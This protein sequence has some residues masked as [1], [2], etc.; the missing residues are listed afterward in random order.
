ML[1][2]IEKVDVRLSQSPLS[3]SVMYFSASSCVRKH[4]HI[5]TVQKQRMSEEN[6][7]TATQRVVVIFQAF[8]KNI[9]V[10]QICQLFQVYNIAHCFN[11]QQISDWTS[12]TPQV[13]RSICMKN[14][15]VQW[16]C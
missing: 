5:G 15:P 8:F 4:R 2:L 10:I 11:S 13:I 9:F 16:I 3:N 14:V 12:T 7:E 6:L 1:K